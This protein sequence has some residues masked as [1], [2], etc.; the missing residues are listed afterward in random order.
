[1]RYSVF[2]LLTGA[3]LSALF[4]P[5]SIRY[6][7]LL[8][9]IDLPDGG[10]HGHPLPTPRL[11]GLALYFAAALS[12][13][14]L[15][16]L[17]AVTGAWLAGSGCL[18]ALGVSDD[19]YTLSPRLKWLAMT[20]VATL[21]VAF[22][23]APDALSLGEKAIA[24]PRP[25]SS[26]FVL[27]WVLLLTNAFNLIDGSDGLAATL[28]SLAACFLFL[29]GAPPSALAVAGAAFGFLPYNRESLP[30]FHPSSATRTFLGDT[31][32]LFLGYSLAVLSLWE[33]TFSLATP[34]YFA[35]PVFDLLRVFLF[36]LLRGKSPFSADRSHLHHILADRGLSRGALLLCYALVTLFCGAIALLWEG[37]I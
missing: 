1:M 26:L 3:V 28:A 17:D 31:G 20:A 22:G 29:R 8:G 9:A 33:G 27:L 16:P 18:T 30:L 21:P 25:L 37:K 10:R 32:A 4:T 11:G 2:L 12:A 23:L 5:L 35:L 19:L 14:F 34:L 7:T 24:L 36:R 13:L 15:L 6:A